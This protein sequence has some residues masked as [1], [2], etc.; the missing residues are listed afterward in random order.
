VDERLAVRFP[1]LLHRVA[2]ATMRLPRRSRLRQ[3]LLRRSAEL[4]ISAYNRRDDE[5]AL[6][7]FDREVEAHQATSSGAPI[8]ADLEASWSGHAGFPR[9]WAQWDEAWTDAYIE[10]AEMLDLG[11][12]VLLMVTFVGHGR[13]SGAEVRQPAAQLHTLRGG[14]VVRWEQWWSWDE[15]RDAVGLRSSSQP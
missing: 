13:H 10:P 2:A 8:G 15:G 9:M 5:A 14:S 12:R 4:G 6:V 7:L 11:D 1:A 3:A